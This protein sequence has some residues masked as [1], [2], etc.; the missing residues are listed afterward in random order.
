MDD[1]TRSLIQAIHDSP[2][3]AVLAAAGVGSAALADLLIAQGRKNANWLI[4]RA[5]KGSP[6]LGDRLHQAGVSFT[7]APVYDTR[8]DLEAAVQVPLQMA[9]GPDYVI[10]ASSQGVHAFVQAGG[11]FPERTLPV[12]IGPYTE[13]ALREE[14]YDGPL[15]LA[16]KAT[17]EGIADIIVRKELQL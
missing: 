17:A 2:P 1:A 16:E 13:Q 14:H 9:E 11:T 15:L 12:C 8:T 3:R 4:Q 7:Q 10:F 6:V 5:A